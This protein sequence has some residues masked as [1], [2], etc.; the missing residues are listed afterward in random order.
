MFEQVRHAR[1]PMKRVI[2]LNANLNI[3]HC[4][5][6]LCDMKAHEGGTFLFLIFER[7]VKCCVDVTDGWDGWMNR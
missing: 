2:G 7:D 3:N 1:L 4:V 6:I 5:S